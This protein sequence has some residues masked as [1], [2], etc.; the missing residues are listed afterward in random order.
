[1]KKTLVAT[2]LVL[3]IMIAALA[4][5]YDLPEKMFR[6]LTQQEQP[7][8]QQYHPFNCSYQFGSFDFHYRKDP[9]TVRVIM[10]G[11]SMIQAGDWGKLLNRDDVANRGIAGDNLPC[12]C[13]RVKYLHD[14]KAKFWVI[15]GGTND[16]VTR[17][18]DTVFSDYKQLIQLIQAT[19]SKPIISLVFYLSPKAGEAYD[20]RKNYKAIN[21]KIKSLNAVLTSYA[22]QKRLLYLDPN[23]EL[24]NNSVLQDQY[25]TDGVHLNEKGYQIWGNMIRRLLDSI[26]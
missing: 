12:M 17:S 22:E 2:N 9:D 18:V 15:E 25:T 23:A 1:M 24:S 6:R 14:V 20:A 3:I 13:Q 4:V 19:G 5:H 10:F 16:I 26:K 21:D 8:P 11:N 7:S